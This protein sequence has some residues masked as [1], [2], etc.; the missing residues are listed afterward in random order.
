MTDLG[1]LLAG[2]ED[3]VERTH[4]D[5]LPGEGVLE[6]TRRAVRRRRTARHVRE[7]SLG[8]VATVLVVAVAWGVQH[9]RTP[10]PAPAD[11]APSPSASSSP[12]AAATPTV[13]PSA[14]A[15]DPRQVGT[16]RDAARA[17][18]LLDSADD[19]WA[20]VVTDGVRVDAP[21]DEYG[22]AADLADARRTVDL[23]SPSGDRTV[24]LDIAEDVHLHSWAVESAQVIATV[25]D[26]ELGWVGG[27]LDLRTGTLAPLPLPWSKQPVGPAV[28][29]ETV[30]VADPMPEGFAGAEGAEGSIMPVAPGML[31]GMDP[32]PMVF[33]AEDVADVAAPVGTLRLFTPDGTERVL[34]EVRLPLRL[35]PL[36]PDRTWFVSQTDDGGL[37]GLDLRTG[38]RHPVAGAPVDP[39]CRLNG[40]ADEHDVLVACPQPDGT[41]RLDALDVAGGGGARPLATSDVPVRDAWPLGDGRVGLGRVVQP[42]PCDVTSDPAVLVDGQV[43]P[44]V[45]GWSP[46]DHGSAL[47]FTGTA[48]WTSVNSCYVGSGRADPQRT[49]RVDMTTGETSTLGW[50]ESRRDR[51]MVVT[52]DGTRVTAVR[53]VRTW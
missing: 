39:A 49:V 48:V 13:Q 45:D 52:P 33:E 41:W 16:P 17:A 23:V 34:G 51:E 15:G 11:V 8:A 12:S 19:G 40:W 21:V 43:R 1:N 42:A 9:E 18:D 14:A 5:A 2:V 46:Y 44:L 20:L 27:T 37:E 35:H 50:L 3:G 36:S 4:A 29:G 47:T 28:T 53:A 31:V 30:W 24:L 26:R 32:E 7:G 22:T 6:R 10:A 25:L 38:E